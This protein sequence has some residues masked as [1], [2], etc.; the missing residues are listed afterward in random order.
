MPVTPP[1]LYLGACRACK[2]EGG[3]LAQGKRVCVWGGGTLA[4]LH[5]AGSV[6][7]CAFPNHIPSAVRRGVGHRRLGALTYPHHLGTGRA[8]REAGSG[9]RHD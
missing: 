7:A 1:A 6:Q 3:A 2:R 8:Q 4:S 5:S 9:S